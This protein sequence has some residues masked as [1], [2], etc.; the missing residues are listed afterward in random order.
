[1]PFLSDLDGRLNA[2]ITQFG[3][4][5]AS[6]S[7]RH[8]DA[9]A[10]AA[11]GVVNLNTGVATTP[12]SVFQIGS[13]TKLFTTAL[14]MQLVDEGRVDLDA[15]VRDYLPEFSVADPVASATVTVRHLL[16]HTGGFD[17]DLFEDFGRG[18]DAL[19]RF[20]EFMASATQF[21]EPGALFSYC[22]SGFCVLGAII[23]RLRGG[24]WEDSMR[25]R[26]IRPLGLTHT[27]LFADEAI[28]FRASTGHQRPPGA[29]ADDVAPRWLMPRSNGPA[30]ATPTATARDL[31]R[32]ADMLMAGGVGPGGTRV[33]SAEAVAA[34]LMPQVPVPSVMPSRWGLGTALFDWT[35]TLV[36][37]HDGATVGQESSVRIVPDHDLVIA[38]VANGSKSYELFDALIPA[39]VKELTGVVRPARPTPPAEPSRIDTT[40]YLGTFAG[41]AFTFVVTAAGDGIDVTTVPGEIAIGLGATET[42]EHWVHLHG[43]AFIRS[44][45]DGDIYPTL[46]FLHD[47][48][49]LFAGRAVPR[50][51]GR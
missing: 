50:V 35:G 17:G 22:N 12:D 15:P 19:D 40:P 3:I 36:Y 32:F 5:G 13:V 8:R 49:F 29:D 27:S 1:M 14:V 42:T 47:R 9:Y 38:V 7:V 23:A 48:T 45:P 25:E 30:G 28:L 37:G 4:P 43:D 21:S 51:G 44:E 2:M 16:S 41:P 18:D 26:L 34:M 31:V 24:T 10:E 6:V 39:I 20:I 33:L 46:T 11:A